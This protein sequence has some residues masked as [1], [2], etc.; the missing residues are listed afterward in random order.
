MAVGDAVEV[1]GGYPDTLSPIIMEVENY[2]DSKE[3]HVGGGPFS[4]FM[5]VG[6]RVSDCVMEMV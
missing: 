6:G 5:I 1:G 4:T 3:S 2:P